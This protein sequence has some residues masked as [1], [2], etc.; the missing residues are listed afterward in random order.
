MKADRA[1]TRELPVGIYNN[2]NIHML[3]YSYY[4]KQH[5]GNWR[6]ADEDQQ[7]RVTTLL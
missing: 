6:R 2:L 5:W 7:I 3:S 4:E 1:Q